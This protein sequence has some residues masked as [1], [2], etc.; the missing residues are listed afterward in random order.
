MSKL[1]EDKHCLSYPLSK[2]V[3]AVCPLMEDLKTKIKIKTLD[4]LVLI[5][6]RAPDKETIKNILMGKLNQVYYEMYT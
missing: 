4:I 1:Y 6:L 3:E 5:T 2:V